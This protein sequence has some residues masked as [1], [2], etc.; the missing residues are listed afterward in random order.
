M[1]TRKTQSNAT[2][3]VDN[4]AVQAFADHAS[5]L[6]ADI[7]KAT[8]I[9]GTFADQVLAL[10]IESL[11]IPA[12]EAT[13]ILASAVTGITDKA[14]EAVRDSNKFKSQLSMAKKLTENRDLEITVESGRRQSKAD[15]DA[16]VAKATRT[17]TVAHLLTAKEVQINAKGEPTGTIQ[18]PLDKA[19]RAVL[20]TENQAKIDA[21]LAGMSEE[22]RAEFMEEQTEKAAQAAVDAANKA[23]ET[24]LDKMPSTWHDVALWIK[25]KDAAEQTAPEKAIVAAILK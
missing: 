19:Y 16:G 21:V 20:A 23:I 22:E 1:A 13:P 17:G 8:V 25:T 9:N 6:V 4:D 18:L 5:R 24:W 12:A 3:T 2:A 11:G 10:T 7:N 14:G 15:K